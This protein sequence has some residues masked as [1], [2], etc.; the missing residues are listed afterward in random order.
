VFCRLTEFAEG[1][2]VRFE[3][4]QE[5]QGARGA[6]RCFPDGFCATASFI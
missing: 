2:E 6:P 5:A 1:E 4:K 3:N